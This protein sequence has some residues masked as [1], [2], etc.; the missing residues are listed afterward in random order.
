MVSWK[1]KVGY[2]E[3]VLFCNVY[4]SVKEVEKRF[5]LS[6][7][8]AW[9]CVK[10]FCCFDEDFLV[11]RDAGITCRAVWIKSREDVLNK[12]LSEDYVF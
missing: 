8:Q 7:I 3:F 12:F 11:E 9:H 4:R 5:G 6:P 2:K 1:E 10:W